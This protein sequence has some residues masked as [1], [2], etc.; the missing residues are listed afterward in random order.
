[1]QDG[2]I[3]AYSTA[4]GEEHH[5]PEHWLTH[6]VFGPQFTTTPPDPETAPTVNNT[7]AEIEKYAADHGIDLEG[8]STKAEMVAVIDAA[9][10][11]STT[12]ST[13]G[14]EPSDETPA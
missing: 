7:K 14:T 2:F 10:P 11:T 6:P 3:V 9:T 1:M 4:T 8:A 5:I 13:D 12:T